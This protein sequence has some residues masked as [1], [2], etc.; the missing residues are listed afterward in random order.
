VKILRGKNAGDGYKV[1]QW[2]NDWITADGH[3]KQNIVL[4]PLNVQLEGDEY[5]RAFEDYTAFWQQGDRRS[6][7]FWQ[8]WKLEL[9]GTFTRRKEET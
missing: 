4:R 6:G 8:L 3:G 2:A 7:M 1:H 9:D 5:W